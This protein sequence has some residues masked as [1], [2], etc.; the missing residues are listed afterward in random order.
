MALDLFVNYERSSNGKMF[1]RTASPGIATFSVAVLEATTL[2]QN[3]GT[4]CDATISI[5]NGPFINFRPQGQKLNT[6]VAFDTTTPCVCSIDVSVIL[7]DCKNS[8]ITHN[9]SISGIFL[10]SLPSVDFIGYPSTYIDEDKITINNLNETNYQ[11]SLGLY[12]YGE[13]HTEII[14][15]SA[16]VAN[17]KWFVGNAI[18]KNNDLV[19]LSWLPI[20]KKSNNTSS[21]SI[22]TVSWQKSSYP[23]NVWATTSAITTAG[24][25]F[26]YN[27]LDGQKEF[28]PFFASTLT[29]DGE[30]DELK[31]TLLRS[32]IEVK[33][34]PTDTQTPQISVLSPFPKHTLTL[35]I[36]YSTQ[37]FNVS[38][39]L[40]PAELNCEEPI[41]SKKLLKEEILGTQWNISGMAGEGGWSYPS[42]SLTATIV[43]YQF[44]LS[45]DKITPLTYLDF[46]KSAA[47]TQ[48]E[49]EINAAVAVGV[50]LNLEPKDWLLRPAYTAVG[51]VSCVIDPLPIPKIYVPNYYNVKNQNVTIGIAEIPKTSLEFERLVINSSRSNDTLTLTK[52]APKGTMSFG[53]VG[54]AELSATTILKN[55]QTNL[56][57]TA[58]VVY[59]NMLEI[60]EEYDSFADSNFFRSTLTPLNFTHNGQP[61]LS[62]NEWAIAD[63]V[64]SIIEKIYT[65]TE[66]LK[67]YSSLYENKSKFYG[68][69][70]DRTVSE[71][72]T[73]PIRFDDL[74]CTE[75][76]FTGKPYV[77]RNEN[78]TWDSF[79][80]TASNSQFNSQLTWETNECKKEDPTCLQKYC[81]DWNW[82]ARKCGASEINVTWKDARCGAEYQK[83]WMFEECELVDGLNCKRTT[84]KISTIDSSFFPIPI[85][86]ANSVCTYTDVAINPTFDSIIVS[87]P[88]ELNILDTTYQAKDIEKLYLADKLY[89]FQN[90]AGIS[91]S[92]DGMLFVLDSVIPRVG[93]FSVANNKFKLY[94]AWG[95]FGLAGNALGLYEPRDIHVDDSNKVWIADT[96]NNCIKKFTISGKNLLTIEDEMLKQNAPISI[97]VDSKQLLHVLTE[98]DV[99]VYDKK[100]TFIFSYTF[101]TGTTKVKKIRPSYNKEVM[102]LTHET[103]VTK[104]FRNGVPFEYLI[105]DYKC[106]SK[107][108]LTNY[109]SVF[110]DAHRNVFVV[111]GD[112]I[113][114]IPDLQKNIDSKV[115]TV[116]ELFWNINDLLIHKEEYIQ[117]WVYLKAFH[118]LWDNIEL[119]RNSLFYDVKGCKSFSKAI[120]NKSDLVI[121]QNEIVTNAVINR[122]SEQLWK[123]LKTLFNYFDPN[124]EN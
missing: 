99:L 45:Y 115:A 42:T 23:I 53:A 29:P 41:S 117:P 72:L 57:E 54:I 104:Y 118:R 107:K 37:Q 33:Q 98:K 110:Q 65:T 79:V 26:S 4:I 47:T 12:F 95:T 86:N 89:S 22:S 34:Y 52:N 123:N 13:G 83:R 91:M 108:T 21:V 51:L 38:V 111:V 59:T 122:L 66:E 9:F 61:K 70:G 74:S 8:P 49:I 43:E 14:Q 120:Y 71:S 28:Y 62:P 80:K 18:T 102:Y 124:C 84:W 85:C 24:P 7:G 55:T 3:I 6:L 27:D 64:N 88:T 15:L 82:K 60:I 69:I 16:S 5:N 11:N 68:W 78:Y 31:T 20:T 76:S 56:E 96:G 19:S 67:K 100:G 105:N 39:M 1:Y 36:N 112:K 58:V 94:T 63:N 25:F 103:G 48:T 35:P 50:K 116:G 109:T 75:C 46:F 93:V 17:S 40:L 119:L 97:C 87:Y 106:Q 81:I 113:L 30:I 2:A 92:K 121:G 114:K 90:I 101:V 44:N 10:D 32:N 73:I 77:T